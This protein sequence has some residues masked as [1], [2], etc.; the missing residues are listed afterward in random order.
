MERE[1]RRTCV[2]LVF[3]YASSRKICVFVSNSLA[4]FEKLIAQNEQRQCL[5]S[6]ADDG[7]KVSILHQSNGKFEEWSG[8]KMVSD[9]LAERGLNELCA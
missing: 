9:H 5:P 4:N 8:S 1:V 6:G 2:H 3:M 7:K